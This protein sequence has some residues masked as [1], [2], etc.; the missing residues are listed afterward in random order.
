[1]TLKAVQ[2]HHLYCEEAKEELKRNRKAILNHDT[3]HDLSVIDSKGVRH[4]IGTF[5]HSEWASEIGKLI[6]KHGLSGIS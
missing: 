4:R 6:E 3:S 5:K 2:W 1:M